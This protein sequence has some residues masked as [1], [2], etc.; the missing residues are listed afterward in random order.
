M[1]TLIG[2]SI[3][4]AMSFVSTFDLFVESFVC[5]VLMLTFFQNIG[6]H[7]QDLIIITLE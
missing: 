3:A 2:N 1:K 5:N 7:R 6:T 4:Q